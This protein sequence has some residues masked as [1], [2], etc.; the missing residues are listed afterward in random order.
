MTNIP[1]GN[2]DLSLSPRS[3]FVT[4]TL[5]SRSV[6]WNTCCAGGGM[7]RGRAPLLPIQMS[8][9]TAFYY[10]SLSGRFHI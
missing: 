3:A 8:D 9:V 6:I 1:K 7:E 4:A 5:L 2:F 10:S